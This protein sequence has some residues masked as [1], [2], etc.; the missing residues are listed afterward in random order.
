MRGRLTK[1]KEPSNPPSNKKLIW[2]AI[3]QTGNSLSTLNEYFYFTCLAMVGVKTLTVKLISYRKT[4]LMTGRAA[5]NYI[6]DSFNEGFLANW[7]KIFDFYRIYLLARKPV[8]PVD[9][10]RFLYIGYAI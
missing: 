3:V 10:K 2:P 8:K 1:L 7:V 5:K 4:C 9:I 6:T